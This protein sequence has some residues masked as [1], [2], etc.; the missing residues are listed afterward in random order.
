MRKNKHW[1]REKE[2]IRLE[3]QL[4]QN[5]EDQRNLG[6]VELPEPIFLGYDAKL[7]PR[8]DI[9][10]REDAWVFWAISKNLSTTTFAKRISDFD[11][12]NKKIKPY[13]TMYPMPHIS[14]ISDR[15]YD[16]IYPQIQKWFDNE[17]PYQGGGWHRFQQSYYCKVPDFY[18]EVVYEKSYKTKSKIFDCILQQ[19]EAEIKSQLYNKFYYKYKD[20]NVPKDFRKRLNRSQRAKSKQILHNI[21]YKDMDCQFVDD[22]RGAGW[23]YW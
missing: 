5:R 2:F 13:Q 12:N 6:W 19:E 21:V 16:T 15:T 17:I 11:W 9:Q 1:S 7:Q 8:T 14:S 3:K 18:W 10:N 23:L 22:Y 20:N 4:S